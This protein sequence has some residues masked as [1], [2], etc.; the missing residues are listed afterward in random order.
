L[1]KRMH[2]L[3]SNELDG[4]IVVIAGA[5]AGHAAT[6]L[7][8]GWGNRNRHGQQPGENSRIGCE[9]AGPSTCPPH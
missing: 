9:L 4:K 1:Q 5:A 7:V 2:P 6:Q 3:H 8:V